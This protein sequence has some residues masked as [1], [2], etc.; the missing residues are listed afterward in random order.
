M[1]GKDVVY[2]CWINEDI[3]VYIYILHSYFFYI[4]FMAVVIWGLSLFFAILKIVVPSVFLVVQ[5]SLYSC[6]VFDYEMYR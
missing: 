4:G 5:S 1:K 2:G 6:V 3:Y